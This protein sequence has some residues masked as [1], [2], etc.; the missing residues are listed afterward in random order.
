VSD[1]GEVKA[2]LAAA[3]AA[4]E[5]KD[6]ARAAAAEARELEELELEAKLEGELGGPRGSAFEI[7]RTLDGLVAVKLGSA[8]VHTKFQAAAEKGG[9]T[10][11]ALHDYVFPNVAHPSPDAYLAMV[12]K[13]PGTAVRCADALATLYGAKAGAD[14]AK[15]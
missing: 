1:A 10:E 2:R 7:V 6:A 9:I 13:R 8:I 5:A 4:K 11:R 12:G 14:D 15:Y 3:R